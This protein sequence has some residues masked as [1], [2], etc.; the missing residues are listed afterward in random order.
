MSFSKMICDPKPATL[1]IFLNSNNIPVMARYSTL[2]T[3]EP[4][5][6]YD[7]ARFSKSTRYHDKDESEE[8]KIEAGGDIRDRRL[9]AQTEQEM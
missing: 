1:C 6:Y 3:A 5:G 7:W 2:S 9:E 4:I 8:T